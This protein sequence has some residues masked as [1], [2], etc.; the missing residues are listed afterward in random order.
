LRAE[1]EIRKHKDLVN[2]AKAVAEVIDPFIAQLPPFVLANY[3]KN[4]DIDVKF[5][6]SKELP[7]VLRK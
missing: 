7:E 6:S 5:N 2:G 1:L 4:F 3:F